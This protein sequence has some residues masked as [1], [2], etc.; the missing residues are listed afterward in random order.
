M[1]F[2]TQDRMNG[3]SRRLAQSESPGE[4]F[5]V[6]GEQ[7]TAMNLAEG[8][9]LNL[10]DA[11]GSALVTLKVSFPAEFRSLEQPTLGRRNLL[12]EDSIH[13]R[14]FRTAQVQHV[15][16]RNAS[17]HEQMVLQYWHADEIVGVPILHPQ[18]PQETPLGVVVLLRQHG[19]VDVGALASLQE[20]LALMHAGLKSWLRL[21][22]LEEMREQATAAV[23]ENQRLL[24]FL[25]DMNS[26]T[27]VDM[28]YE[29]FAA[30][31][32][33]QL[34]FDLAA[35]GLVE[36]DMMATKKIC[37]AAPRDAAIADE[38][39][40][41]MEQNPYPLDPRVSGAV[42]V[43]SRNESMLFPD[44]QAL[45]D[46]P[47]S[48]HDAR[49]V[50]ILKTARTLFMS[51]IRYQK[52]AIGIF[53]LY[54]LHEPIALTEADMHLLQ[55]LSSFLGTAIT[56]SQTYAISQAQNL[57]IGH[58]N[59][60]LQEKVRELAEQASTDRLT[61]LLN[62]RSYEREMSKRIKECQRARDKS[63]FS[64]ALIDID[65]FKRFNDSYG[66]AA[67]NDVLA[68]V[69]AEIGRVIRASDTA[70][71]YGGEEFAVSLPKCDMQGALLLAERIRAAIEAHTF[72]TEGGTHRITVSIGCASYQPGDTQHTL[73]TR[74][75][76][77]LYEA[78]GQGRNRVCSA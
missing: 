21:S 73:F 56:N 14:A 71:R 77:A 8:Y 36:G 48:E 41:F 15:D 10:L 45:K 40:D 69:A 57:E 67:G 28:I 33:R 16:A 62:F 52:K 24:Q 66:H 38:W 43:L 25:D 26:L 49:G 53:V 1:A 17:E 55:Q 47:M 60:M 65:Y 18:R 76:Q 63:D 6:L 31:L 58:L 74:A 46:L 5:D 39:R 34:P 3:I 59:E 23:A 29:M 37:V 72:E 22:H 32:F 54:S 61:G 35:F 42:L 44:I 20:V 70:F 78:K 11:G 27:S 19:H 50:A 75:D 13:S 7:I 12:T 68:G 64:L 9:L 4:V 51:P 30:E 2:L